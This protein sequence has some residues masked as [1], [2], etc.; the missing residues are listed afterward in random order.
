MHPHV[1]LLLGKSL[2][3]EHGKIMQF[4]QV[5]LSIQYN[6]STAEWPHAAQPCQIL[7]SFG[8]LMMGLV[9]CKYLRPA[10]L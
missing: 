4:K 9:S 2:N 1:L 10:L 3:T 8:A 7:G 6:S 5:L